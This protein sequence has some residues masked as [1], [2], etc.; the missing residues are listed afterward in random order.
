[1]VV[2]QDGI[3]SSDVIDFIKSK[4]PINCRTS[5]YEGLFHMCVSKLRTRFKKELVEAF[6][7]LENFNGNLKIEETQKSLYHEFVDSCKDEENKYPYS[8]EC[9]QLW[10]DRGL[11]VHNMRAKDGESLWC[12]LTVED[13]YA[14]PG[15]DGN[16][17][18]TEDIH[19]KYDVLKKA[20][21]KFQ[22]EDEEAL[23]A[24]KMLQFM[25]KK[26]EEEDPVASEKKIKERRGI[27]YAEMSK[28]VEGAIE[29][30]QIKEQNATLMRSILKDLYF[31]LENGYDGDLIE[32]LLGLFLTSDP[33][34]WIDDNQGIDAFALYLLCAKSVSIENLDLFAALPGFNI[35]KQRIKKEENEEYDSGDKKANLGEPY[36]QFYLGLKND[37]FRRPTIEGF[38]WFLDKGADVNLATRPVSQRDIIDLI[39]ADSSDLEGNETGDFKV[40][41]PDSQVSQLV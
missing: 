29:A 7:K 25:D 5:E 38:K 13:R 20:G 23:H 16:R 33:T 24:Q 27:K 11:D 41:K 30:S 19:D 17:M 12:Y 21:Y 9:L 36:L 32:K 10:I 6:L 3:Y 40:T 34:T 22:D 18:Y 15:P 39:F 28:K 31:E 4:D 2:A 14:I 37:C 1:M 8:G 26:L 35:N